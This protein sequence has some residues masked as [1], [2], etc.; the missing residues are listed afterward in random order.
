MIKK[1]FWKEKKNEVIPSFKCPICDEGFLIPDD[2]TLVK[3]NLD[4]ANQLYEYTAEIG[5]AH[6]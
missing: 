1:E 4:K 6:V 3:I 5:R 2:K